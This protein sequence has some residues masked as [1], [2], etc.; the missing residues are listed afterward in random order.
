MLLNKTHFII[1]T[2]LRF[3]DGKANI[4]DVEKIYEKNMTKIIPSFNSASL[5]TKISRNLKRLSDL[6]RTTSCPVVGLEDVE[7]IIPETDRTMNPYYNCLL[8]GN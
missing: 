7:E 2:P 4:E 3:C 6:I 8:C 1:Y 5:E